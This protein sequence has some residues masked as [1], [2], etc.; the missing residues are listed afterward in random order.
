MEKKKRGLFFVGVSAYVERRRTDHEKFRC[1]FANV[2]PTMP[3][4]VL[5]VKR[6]S[7]PQEVFLPADGELDLSGDAVLKFL[8]PVMEVAASFAPRRDGEDQGT[9]PLIREAVG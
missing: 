8:A 5:E 7:L 6:I 9:E 2:H 1:P 4:I 3:D